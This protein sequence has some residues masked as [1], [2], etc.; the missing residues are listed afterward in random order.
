MNNKGADQIV[1]IRTGLTA[2][3]LFTYGINRFS[4]DVAQMILKGSITDDLKEEI[5]IFVWQQE[6]IGRL[7]EIDNSLAIFCMATYGE[8]DPTDNAQ[9]MYEW[10]QNGEVELNGLNYAVSK[11][12]YLLM[13]SGCP[14]K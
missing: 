14:R 10:L 1:R 7:P 2:P 3:L 4:H 6:D 8:G 13:S 9:E 12:L 11:V 5:Y